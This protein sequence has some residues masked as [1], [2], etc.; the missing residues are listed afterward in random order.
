MK[1]ININGARDACWLLSLG[2]GQVRALLM[3]IHDAHPQMAPVASYLEN[4]K[5]LHLE[6]ILKLESAVL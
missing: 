1:L 4:M 6:H 2:L 3:R 5:Y